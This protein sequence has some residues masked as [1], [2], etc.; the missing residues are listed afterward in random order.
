MG[1]NNTFNIKEG[2]QIDKNVQPNYNSCY[3]ETVEKMRDNANIMQEISFSLVGK[4]HKTLTANLTRPQIKMS[5][6]EDFK[7]LEITE[8]QIIEQFEKQCSYFTLTGKKNFS[9]VN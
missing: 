4:N 7:D 8:I 3:E 5:L 6:L 9:K 2:L 1:E